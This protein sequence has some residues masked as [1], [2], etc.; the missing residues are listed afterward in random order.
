ML[1]GI[2]DRHLAHHPGN[3]LSRGVFILFSK[4]SIDVRKRDKGI[5]IHDVSYQKCNICHLQQFR[6]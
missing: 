2:Q 4:L 3:I 6:M 5:Y 1:E